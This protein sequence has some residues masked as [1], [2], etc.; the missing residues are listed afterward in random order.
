MLA[1]CLKGLRSVRRLTD[2][3]LQL[4]ELSVSHRRQ[5]WH[6]CTTNAKKSTASSPRSDVSEANISAAANPRKDGAGG[7][8]VVRAFSPGSDEGRFLIR[9]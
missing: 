5:G 7:N 6:I 9:L 2:L 1:L 8:E 3:A 4:S